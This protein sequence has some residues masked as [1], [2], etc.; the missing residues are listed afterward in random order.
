MYPLTL[1]ALL[2]FPSFQ[3]AVVNCSISTYELFVV[4]NPLCVALPC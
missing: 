4:L 3:L 2:R 1:L